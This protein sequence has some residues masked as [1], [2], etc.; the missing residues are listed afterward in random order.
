MYG[1]HPLFPVDIEFGVHTPDI[2]GTSTHNYIKKLQSHFA[3]ISLAYQKD[4]EINVKTIPNHKHQYDC[5]VCC[6]RL[7][8]RNH[9]L[10]SQKSF[11]G[12]HKIQD[13]WENVPYSVVDWVKG[14]PVH[15][16]QCVIAEGKSKVRVLHHNM[17]FQLM[18]W[19]ECEE[20]KTAAEFDISDSEVVDYQDY[21]LADE[22]PTYMGPLRRSRAKAQKSP[23]ILVKANQL[24]N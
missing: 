6:P 21:W 12:K 15:K 20:Q 5:K 24:D 14:L 17:L 22:I 13:R 11:I 8:S 9:V 18:Q 3:L 2:L 10:V 19:A 4:K 7:E 16:I 23:T 1:R